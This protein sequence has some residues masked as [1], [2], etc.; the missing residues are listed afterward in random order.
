MPVTS[1]AKPG[2]F[3]QWLRNNPV[4]VVTIFGVLLYVMFSIPSIIFYARLGTSASEVG[5]T[6]SSVLSGAAFGAVVV[7]AIL[8]LVV[9]EIAYLA[10][11][12]L[13]GGLWAAVIIWLLFHLELAIEDWELDAKQFER[14]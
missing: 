7:L 6:Y 2:G 4:L 9:F 1:E 11:A 10:C 14:K 5:F 13:V 8:I 3:S 12:F